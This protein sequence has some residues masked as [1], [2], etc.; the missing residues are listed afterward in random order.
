MNILAVGCH[1]DDLEIGCGGTL[2]K[3]AKQGHKV[4]MCHVANGCLGHAVLMPEELKKI[5]SEEAERASKIIGASEVF[6]LCIDDLKVDAMNPD[7]IAKM[8]DIIRYAKPDLI[9]THGPDD[10]MTDHVQT[11][12]LVFN[13]SFSCSVPHYFTKHESFAKIVPIYYM[14]TLAGINFLP[15]EYVDISEYIEIKLNAVECHES[16]VKWMKDHDK[17]DFLDFVKTVSKFRGL[18][19]SVGFAE[20]FKQCKTWPRLITERLLP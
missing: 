4:L 8:V 11:G 7:S 2:A 9:I 16:Q 17:I 13:A 10:Y 6:C 19:S 5:R 12:E 14:D 1:P 20:G 18:Q 15:D 3:Y